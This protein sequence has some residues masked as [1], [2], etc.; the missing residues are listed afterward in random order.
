MG[1]AATGGKPN[2][3]KDRANTL[4]LCGLAFAD[5]EERKTTDT[6]TLQTKLRMLKRVSLR[7][8]VDGRCPPT[9]FGSSYEQYTEPSHR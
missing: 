2:R 3:G 7:E 8:G 1:S 6:A 5:A 9:P 4:L